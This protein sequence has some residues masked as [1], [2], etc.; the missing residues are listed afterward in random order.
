[1][2]P[3]T[4]TRYLSVEVVQPD[5]QVA[6]PYGPSPSFRLCRLTDGRTRRSTDYLYV[7]MHGTRP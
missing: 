5:I 6:T 2:A 1:M 3:W 4:A 7:W